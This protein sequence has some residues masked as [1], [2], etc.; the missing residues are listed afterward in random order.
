[1]CE[2]IHV[3]QENWG[4]YLKILPTFPVCQEGFHSGHYQTLHWNKAAVLR[5]IP[6]NT[7]NLIYAP[8][9]SLRMCLKDVEQYMLEKMF[10]QL[11]S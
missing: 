3:Y 6:F 2:I 8:E 5:E 1:M 9:Q 11:N 4:L 7:L 10:F